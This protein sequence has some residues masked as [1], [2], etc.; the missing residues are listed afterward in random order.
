MA[1]SRSGARP[2]GAFAFALCLLLGATLVLALPGGAQGRASLEDR[3]AEPVNIVEVRAGAFDL[4]AV[5]FTEGEPEGLTVPR[6]CPTL[7]S[8]RCDPASIEVG[9]DCGMDWMCG[10][11]PCLCGSADDWGGCSCNGLVETFPSVHYSSSD[12]GVVRVVEAG[13]RAWLVPVGVGTATVT[14][15]ASLAYHEGTAVEVPVTVAGLLLADAVLA[16]LVLV[17]VV[18]LVA[19]VLGVRAAVRRLWG[20]MVSHAAGDGGKG[21]RRR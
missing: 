10:I 14:C 9:V 4:N 12:E 15:A 17:A 20:R 8:A 13:G 7:L 2:S 5:A 21:G 18:L 1:C 16:V 19:A 6:I 11:A 3:E